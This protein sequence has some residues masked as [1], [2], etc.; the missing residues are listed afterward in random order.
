MAIL[1][2]SIVSLTFACDA[3]NE[4]IYHY[5]LR[6]RTNVVV[7]TVESLRADRVTPKITPGLEAL[8]SKG[9]RFTQAQ[10]TSSWA[11]PAVASAFTGLYSPRHGLEKALVKNGKLTVDRLNLNH[12]TLAEVMSEYGYA[13]YGLS[14]NGRMSRL[15]GFDQGMDRFD[16]SDGGSARTVSKWLTRIMPNILADVKNEKP[17]FLWLHYSDPRYPYLPQRPH[18]DQLAPKW[19]K[20]V[21]RLVINDLVT[22]ARNG[23]FAK[24]E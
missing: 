13:T 16:C 11:P 17:Y 10:S 18:I 4:S 19:E 15:Y 1:F 5:G 7:I 12:I 23:E 6:T 3:I 22:L 20:R 2:L 24:D 21:D 14:T 9:I 8:A